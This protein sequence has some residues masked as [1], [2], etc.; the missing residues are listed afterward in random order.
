MTRWCWQDL[1]VLSLGASDVELGSLKVAVE[2]IHV[3]ESVIF[4]F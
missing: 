2:V 4:V 3:D 1:D